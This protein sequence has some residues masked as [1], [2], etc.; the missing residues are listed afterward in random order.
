MAG[1]Y[2]KWLVGDASVFPCILPTVDR[3]PDPCERLRCGRIVVVVRTSILPYPVERVDAICA[4]ASS[5]TCGCAA[6]GRQRRVS[7][8][9]HSPRRQRFVDDGGVVAWPR[10]RMFFG[11]DRHGRPAIVVAFLRRRWHVLMLTRIGHLCS[12]RFA[13]LREAASTAARS[14]DSSS[15]KGDTRCLEESPTGSVDVC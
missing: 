1:G 15:G 13:S 11:A 10:R 6:I 4:R 14:A 2:S 12:L 5:L 7:L 3:C 8:L 9:C